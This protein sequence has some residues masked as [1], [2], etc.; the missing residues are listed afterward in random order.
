MV[1]LHLLNLRVRMWHRQPSAM[2]NMSPSIDNHASRNVLPGLSNP[3]RHHLTSGL[4]IHRLEVR[5]SSME[6]QMGSLKGLLTPTSITCSLDVKLGGMICNSVFRLMIRL[7]MQA[8]RWMTNKLLIRIFGPWI[9]AAYAAQIAWIQC[10]ISSSSIHA[11]PCAPCTE[12]W[13]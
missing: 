1:I 4:G 6:W 7:Q 12:P 13:W 2:F 3:M 10:S 8:V 11:L 5:K 9:I